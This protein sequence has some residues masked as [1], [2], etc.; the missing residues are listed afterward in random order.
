[1]VYQ[2][3]HGCEMYCPDLVAMGSNHGRVNLAMVV[4][5]Y[6]NKNQLREHQSECLDM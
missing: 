3:S 2:T 1:M 5:Y 4:A 6:M